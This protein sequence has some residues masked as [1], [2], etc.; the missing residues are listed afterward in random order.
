MAEIFIRPRATDGFKSA[1][2]EEQ[3]KIKAAIEVLRNGKLPAHTKKLNSTTSG[4][5]IRVGKWRILFVLWRGEIDIVDIFIKK[6]KMITKN[7]S[8]IK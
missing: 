5:R 3:Q 1:G 4:Y 7:Y 2:K 8:I 6:A